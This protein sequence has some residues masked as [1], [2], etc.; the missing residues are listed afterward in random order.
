VNNTEHAVKLANALAFVCRAVETQS[1]DLLCSVLLLDQEGTRLFHGAAPSLPESYTQA[2]NGMA[3]GPKAGS[4]GTAAHLGKPVIVTD[5]A[6]DPLWADF[7]HLALPL[8]LRACWSTPILS[9]EG[10][11][12]ATFAL[13]HREARGPNQ[14]EQQIVQWATSLAAYVIEY[15]R[16]SEALE[17]EREELELIL[18]ASPAMIFYKDRNNRI[19]RVNRAAADSLGLSKR[20]L[21]G[22]SAFDLY[23]AEGTKYY[24][25]DLEV[26]LTGRPKIGI[27]ETTTTASGE[28]RFVIT[29]KIPHLDR[30]GN[31]V[32][33]IVF[34][35]DITEQTRA[36]KALKHAE[37]LLRQS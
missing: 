25:D 10:K 16:I 19:V 18:D 35:R 34:A 7:R 4:C 11:V 9:R 3:I 24:Q 37:E 2:I 17:E 12:L 15:R 36:E 13:Y 21:Q 20:E 31:I 30:D 5:I 8:G 32:G 28:E 33:V 14:R 23:P 29:D 27:H 22:R 26:I 1:G 6:K